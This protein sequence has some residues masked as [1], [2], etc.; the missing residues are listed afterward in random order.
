MSP[1]LYRCQ[2]CDWQGECA[3]PA[4]DLHKRHLPGDVFS[5]LECPKCG[6]LVH[7]LDGYGKRPVKRLVAILIYEHKHGRDVSA[8]GSYRAAEAALVSIVRDQWTDRAD[9]EAP[10]DASSLSDDEAI[11]A[12]FDGHE[13][14]FYAIEEIE[15]EFQD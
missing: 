8:Y 4:R 7:P 12:Y 10:D 11:N 6:A 1:S 15:V 14:E 2:N 5:D 3:V 9:R 13:E